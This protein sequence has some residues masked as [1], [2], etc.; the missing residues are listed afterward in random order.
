MFLIGLPYISGYKVEGRIV[1]PDKKELNKVRV[2]LDDG[3]YIGFVKPDGRFTIFNVP[4]KG[5]Y[6]TQVLSPTYVF[7]PVRVEITSKGQI[8]ARKLSHLK[9]SAVSL[10]H[11]PLEMRAIGTPKYFQQREKF[12]IFDMLKNHVVFLSA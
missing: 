9:P 2:V 6:I 1:V 11:Y 3:A 5:S 8:R 12:S 7:E 4:S 10:L